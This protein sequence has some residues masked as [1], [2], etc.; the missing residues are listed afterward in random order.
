MLQ[1]QD[2]E[3]L[4]KVGQNLL[5]ILDEEVTLARF[6]PNADPDQSEIQILPDWT[7]LETLGLS[8]RDIGETIQ[9]AI[10]GI[11]PTELQRGDRLVDI[12]VQ[13]QEKDRENINQ[14]AE[15]PLLQ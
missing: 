6:R 10:E 15:I 13:L 5:K 8:A 7:R 14:L 1:S 4:D 2:K 3:L 11:V 9:T 12:R